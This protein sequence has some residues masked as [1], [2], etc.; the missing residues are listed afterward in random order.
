MLYVG[1]TNNLS[2][3]VTQHRHSGADTF[4]GRYKAHCLVYVEWFHEIRDAIRREKQI[5]GMGR[6]K[7]EE[8]IRTF[9]PELV[10]L[11]SVQM[12]ETSGAG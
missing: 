4:C 11:A 2:R 8:L 1:V 5:K 9:N 6:R 7:K 12:S 10:D 3:R